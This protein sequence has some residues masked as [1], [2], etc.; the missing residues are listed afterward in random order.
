MQAGR[1]IGGNGEAVRMGCKQAHH[2]CRKQ[3]QNHCRGVQNR[4]LSAW[5]G[6]EDRG[7]GQGTQHIVRH[8]RVLVWLV[9]DEKADQQALWRDNFRAE[10]R[11]CRETLHERGTDEF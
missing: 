11:I 3:Q 10:H 7:Q 8:H 1:H 6:Q 4:T 9:E 5:G 2:G